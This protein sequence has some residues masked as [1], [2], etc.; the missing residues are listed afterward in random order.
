[1]EDTTV[2]RTLFGL[3]GYIATMT[4]ITVGLVLMSLTRK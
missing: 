2:I 4:T 3:L 1:M